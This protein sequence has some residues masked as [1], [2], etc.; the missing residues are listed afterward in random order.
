MF[1]YIPEQLTIWMIAGQGNIYADMCCVV[2]NTVI[3]RSDRR[4]GNNRLQLYYGLFTLLKQYVK[5]AATL[6]LAT[7]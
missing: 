1:F 4:R 5:I 6:V 2:L 7:L 3:A